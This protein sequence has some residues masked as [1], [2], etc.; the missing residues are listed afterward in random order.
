M[1]ELADAQDLKSCGPYGP[2]GF[3]PRSG[4]FDQRQRLTP[5][6][7]AAFVGLFRVCQGR[8]TLGVAVVMHGLRRIL[9][10][11]AEVVLG[12]LQKVLRRHRATVSN[13]LAADVNRVFFGQLGFPRRTEILK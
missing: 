11:L 8:L 7:I 3:D 1:A 12:D 13:P 9:R 6:A 5:F 10:R 2:C 4:Y